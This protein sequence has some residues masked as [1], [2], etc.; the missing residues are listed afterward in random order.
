MIE[1]IEAVGLIVA[2]AV[3]AGLIIGWVRL[4]AL[5]ARAGVARETGT[6]APAGRRA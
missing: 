4:A 6:L 3:A 5:R 1:I 2:V